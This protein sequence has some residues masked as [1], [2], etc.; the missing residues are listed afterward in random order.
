VTEAEEAVGAEA[1]AQ[2][3][4]PDEHAAEAGAPVIEPATAE[5]GEVASDSEA[6]SGSGSGSG[7]GLGPAAVPVDVSPA[8]ALWL[9]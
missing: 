6:A 1:M 8:G 7:S 5:S 9:A 4:A 2:V 3:T